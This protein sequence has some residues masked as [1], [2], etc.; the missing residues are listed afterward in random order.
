[1]VR[2]DSP[3]LNH[4][5]HRCA[6]LNLQ[7]PYY[8]KPQQERDYASGHWSSVKGGEIFATAF[9]KLHPG[10]QSCPGKERSTVNVD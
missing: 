10:P 8:F 6:V 3:M 2:H 1:M 4:L 5:S 7:H 9:F